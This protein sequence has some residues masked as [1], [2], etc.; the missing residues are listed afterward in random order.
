MNTSSRVICYGEILWDL[1]PTGEVPGGAPMNVAYHLNKLGHSPA[2]ITRIGK[3]ER[4]TKLIALLEGKNIAT[5]YV[6][7]DALLPTGI[8]YATPNE[9][10][11][12]EYEIVAPV[13]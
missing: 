2:V 5:R 10:K 12:M 9:N 13:A 8:V 3:D 11:E 6:Q 4:G 1:L 7:V